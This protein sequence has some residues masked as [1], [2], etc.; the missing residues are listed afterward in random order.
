MNIAFDA[1]A[2]LANMSKDGEDGAWVYDAIQ[3][4]MSDICKNDT[5]FCMNLYNKS[6][7]GAWEDRYSNFRE[8]NYYSGEHI[9]IIRLP[10]YKPVF[11]KIITDFIKQYKIDIFII[12]SA[13]DQVLTVYE[14]EWF[15]DVST[16]VLVHNIESFIQKDIYFT[17][18]SAQKRYNEQLYVLQWADKCIAKSTDVKHEIMQMSDIVPENIMILED[19][20]RQNLYTINA[21]VQKTIERLD[22]SLQKIAF[23]A[24]LPPI[25]S[26][27]AYYSYHILLELS[28]YL[29]VDVFIDNEYTVECIF[30]SN[31]KIYRHYEFI[32][33][34][35][36]YDEIIYQVGNNKY[37]TYI[38]DYIKEFP[39]I[40]D[41]HDYNLHSILYSLYGRQIGQKFID[42][43]N[44]LK[45][46]M[47]ENDIAKFLYKKYSSYT[48]ADSSEVIINGF[49]VNYAKKVIVHNQF[50]KRELLKKNVLRNVSVVPLYVETNRISMGKKKGEQ[51][52]FSSF[53][54][55]TARKRVVPIIKAFERIVKEGYDAKLLFVGELHPTL[56]K[57][58]ERYAGRE[59]IKDRVYS[60][61]YVSEEEFEEYLLNCD[62]GI[63]LRYPYYGETSGP[64]TRLMGMGKCVIIN[65]IGSFSEIPDEVCIKIPSVEKMTNIEE[66]NILY[67]AMK[68][69]LD[70]KERQRIGMGA[71]EYIKEN[72]CIDIVGKKYL[73]AISNIERKALSNEE[74]RRIIFQD[75]FVIEHGRVSDYE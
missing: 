62:V 2:M 27:I 74:L 39:G 63:S 71:F 28:R 30:P 66:V 16:V 35:K 1:T 23:F 50:A 68:R 31:V 57:D 75:Q 26:G 42:F 58:F 9:E 54:F 46:D 45:E 3:I 40:V 12:T 20:S 13:F 33:H 64:L 70:E 48:C 73:D 36:E 60:T 7:E 22:D 21:D 6:L 38:F 72:M 67:A 43:K 19:M 25:E 5:F 37:H 10:E 47:T 53:G 32:H 24:P 69:C 18:Y 56:E 11:Q 41:L 14:K 34:F 61:G 65:D 44:A 17:S 8:I 59:E 15:K 49:A 51:I 29:D 55:L 4:L 52:V